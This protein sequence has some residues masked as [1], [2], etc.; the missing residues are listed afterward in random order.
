MIILVTIIHVLV[1]AFLVLVILLQQ[2]R[3]GGMG[4]AF[5]GA[6]QQVFGGAG[7]GNF[8]TRLTEI[9]ALAFVFTSFMLAVLASQ[10]GPSALEQAAKDIYSS[11]SVQQLPPPAPVPPAP[12][13]SSSEAVPVLADEAGVGSTDDAGSA[14]AVDAGSAGAVG[15]LDG[16]TA[17][18]TTEAGAARAA[19]PAHAA[20]SAD[21]AH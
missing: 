7:A 3:G 4:A 19:A 14:G 5:G 6:S 8:L 17:T 2:G 20:V 13:S 21:A 11:T 18:V 12:L 16:A 1:C 15:A 9:S 10:S